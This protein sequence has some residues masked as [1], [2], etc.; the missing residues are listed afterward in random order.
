[1]KQLDVLR[2]VSGDYTDGNPAVN[3][4]GCSGHWFTEKTA[5]DGS[6]LGT[7][8]AQWGMAANIGTLITSQFAWSKKNADYDALREQIGNALGK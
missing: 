7:V 2:P 8:L 4:L 5:K 3:G 1:M 6:V